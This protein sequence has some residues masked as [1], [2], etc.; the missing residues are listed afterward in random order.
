MHTFDAEDLDRWSEKTHCKIKKTTKLRCNLGYASKLFS[1]LGE[2]KT[3][4]VS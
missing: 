3:L 4:I 2:V 1:Q